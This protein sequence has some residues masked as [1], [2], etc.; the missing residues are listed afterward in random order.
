MC[1][2]IGGGKAAAGAAYAS[3]YE[4]S[5]VR[6]PAANYKEKR[7]ASVKIDAATRSIEVRQ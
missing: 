7:K 2:A 5:S 6:A 4:E 1:G 3:N